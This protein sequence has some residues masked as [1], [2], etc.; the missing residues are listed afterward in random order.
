MLGIRKNTI[1]DDIAELTVLK[2][3][4]VCGPQPLKRGR[5]RASLEIDPVSRHVIGL[6]MQVGRAEICLLNLMG[7]VI[8][9]PR[10]GVVRGSRALIPAAAKLLAGAKSP[11]T[12]SIGLAT[13]G[14]LDLE[15]REVVMGIL[16]PGPPYRS[17]KP[18]LAAASKIPLVVENDVHAMSAKWL[19]SQT[20]DEKETVLMV[21]IADGQLGSALLVDG[22]PT[23]GCVVASHE[24]GHTRF[25]LK[26]RRCYCGQLGCLERIFSSDYL[27]D[28]VKE[29]TPLG[30]ALSRFPEFQSKLRPLVSLLGCGIANVVSFLR[31]HRLVLVGEILS[32]PMALEAV[33]S[34]I[35]DQT[36]S[37]LANRIQMQFWD[38]PALRSSE[39]AGW[40]ALASI[41]RQGW[42]TA[43]PKPSGRRGAGV[44]PAIS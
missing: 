1:S 25:P 21:F 23:P 44:Q 19:L 10:R 30:T 5:P 17:I 8:A 12:F 43:S 37:A 14:L 24:L 39:M 33:M 40:L 35:R 16:D 31:P 20:N 18:L 28:T 34:S 13:P 15:K 36:L 32:H 9:E 6:S 29:S 27:R 3:V 2:L 4:R 26:T 38:Q 42:L 7:S 22:H 41:Y 11:E